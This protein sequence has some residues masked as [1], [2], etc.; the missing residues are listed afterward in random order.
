MSFWTLIFFGSALE[1]FILF[2]LIRLYSKYVQTDKWWSKER[3]LK[4]L[5]LSGVIYQVIF[6]GLRW[7]EAGFLPFATMFE[8]L[9]L[10]SLIIILLFLYFTRKDFGTLS[11][12]PFIAGLIMLCGYIFGDTAIVPRS[13]A[14][15]SKWFE[16]HIVAYFAGYASCIFAFVAIVSLALKSEKWRLFYSVVP[17]SLIQIT[18][19]YFILWSKK[20]HNRHRFYI[21]KKVVNNKETQ[22][23]DK[24]FHSSLKLAFTCILA[25]LITGSFW[26]NE[27]YC[28]YWVW[29]NKENWGF[30]TWLVYVVILHGSWLKFGIKSK[31]ALSIVAMALLNY[32]YFFVSH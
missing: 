3:S 1:T 9:S 7:Y 10:L 17:D 14:L 25:G 31:V 29:G 26:A 5:I 18:D 21:L 23:L 11:C 19:G 27:M 16:M 32:T 24:L 4:W 13:P 8:S 22:R 20:I 12:V 2:S 30:V 15:Q 6:F 28:S